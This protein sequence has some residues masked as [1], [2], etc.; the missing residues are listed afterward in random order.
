MRSTAPLMLAT[1]VV[2]LAACEDHPTAPSQPL[3]VAEAS[4]PVKFWNAL[5]S[6]DWNARAG[7]LAAT[8]AAAGRPV[9]VGRLYPYL[10]L[11]QY[12]A[13]EAAAAVRPH[14]PIS[15]AI[16]GA[17]AAVLA[18]YFPGHLAAIEAA[19]DAQASAP[20]WPGAKHADFAAGETLGREI[21]AAVLAWSAGDGFGLTSPGTPPVGPGYW[22]WTGGPIARGNLGMRPFFL[23]SADE[24]RPPPPPAFG[25]PAFAAA[26]AQ[27]RSISDTRTPEQLASAI[28]WHVNQSPASNGPMNALARD[29][30]VE[31]HR[32]DRDAARILFLANAASFDAL[33]GCF[34]AKYHYWF[35]RP[36][37]AD[38]LIV[39]AVPLPPHPS[40]PSAH[41]CNSGAITETLALLFPRERARVEAFAQ[42][43]GL[44][45]VYG[46]IHYLF[47]S[48]A[49]LQ[50]GRDVAAKAVAANLDQV[51]V[52]P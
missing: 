11:A 23:A 27:V 48:E 7:Q 12:R 49:G 50:L 31:H 5:A 45:R 52:I 32:N 10:S 51:A 8:E 41:S 46:G 39:T 2:A 1:V 17:S 3:A 24:F 19:L 36:S 28:Y 14:P 26:L 4:A 35:I 40:Y 25:S 20:A 44:S 29:I 30:I 37:Q 15:A 33:I 6:V 9:N 47:D 42:E 34:D 21:A 22:V 18:A 38:P 13:A 16:G 43:A